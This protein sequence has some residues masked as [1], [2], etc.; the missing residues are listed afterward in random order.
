MSVGINIMKLG[1]WLLSNKLA[2]NTD[3]TKIIIFHPKSKN[4][5]SEI[6]FVFNNNN[7][8]AVQD[9]GFIYPIERIIPMKPVLILLILL[10]KY[11]ESGLMKT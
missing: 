2:I 1:V 10:L 6:N 9:Q 5:F 8:D 7:I 11:S 4:V 3:K